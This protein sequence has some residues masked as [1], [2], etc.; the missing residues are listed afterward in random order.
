MRKAVSLSREAVA[1]STKSTGVCRSKHRAMDTRWRWP[2]ESPEPFS[3]QRQSSPFSWMR[4]ARP[5]SSSARWTCWGGKSRNMVML[6]RKVLLNTNT[7]C[8][9]M[10]TSS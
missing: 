4:G 9:T 10:D 8:S 5:E 6:S 2:P 3:P 1:S 7:F